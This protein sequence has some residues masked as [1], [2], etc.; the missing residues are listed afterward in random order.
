MKQYE[1]KIKI[2]A[3]NDDTV[4]QLGNLLQNTVHVVDNQDLIKLL[5]K[6][7]QNPQIVKTALKFI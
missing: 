1:V 2:S 4:R 6:V 7:K 3:P 5:T